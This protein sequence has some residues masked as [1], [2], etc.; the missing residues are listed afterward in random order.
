MSSFINRHL[1]LSPQEAK[2]MLSFIQC[3]TLDQLI[4]E[5]IPQHIRTAPTHT[6]G[7]ATTEEAF[8]EHI[9][10]IA[11]QNKV[12][13]SY[14]GQG[15]YPTH[16]PSVIKRNVLENPGWYT[17]YTPYQS[18][19]AQGRLECLFYFQTI[20]CE[21]TKLPIANA[22]LLDEATAAAE[23]MFMMYSHYCSTHQ[24]NDQHTCLMDT[25]IFPQT[26]NVIYTRAKA[27]GIK[28]KECDTQ[29]ATL[30]EHVF[31]IIVQYPSPDGYIPDYTAFIQQ[32]QQRHIPV[33]MI[34]DI[35]SLC[36]LEPCGTLG[37]SIA[38]GST[39]RLG[40]PMGMGGPHAAFLACKDE[41]KRIIPG[42]IIGKTIDAHGKPCYRMA[43][44][45]R[46][47]HIKREKATSNICTAQA[48]L[49]NMA[50]LYVIYHGAR[51]LMEISQRIASLAHLLALEIKA[52]DTH[53][54]NVIHHHYFD[55][56]TIAATYIDDIRKRAE[57]EQV[58]LFYHDDGQHIGIAL[59]ETTTQE[60]I[61]QLIYI[62]LGE[63]NTALQTTYQAYNTAIPAYA[64]RKDTFLTHEVFHSHTTETK[65]MRFLHHLEAKDLALNQSMIP[66]GSCTMKLNAATQLMPLSMPA[67]ANIHPLA[68]SAQQ[69]G[70]RFI[71]HR[72][73]QM[74]CSITQMDACS[75]QP[76]S[77]AQGE[78]AGLLCIKA[79]HQH[80]R[81]PQRNIMLIPISAHGT[82]PASA[83]VAG[84]DIMVIK[85]LDNGAIDLE[86]LQTIVQQTQGLLAGLMIT[87]PSTYGVFDANISQVTQLIHDAGG[88]VYMDGA[89]MN[90]QVGLTSPNT[91]GADVCH[92]NLHKTFAIPHGGGG[93]GMGPICV[94][95][96]L[97]P[98]LPALSNFKQQHTP[99]LA[100]I[101]AAPYGS[102]SI[103][104][105]AYAYIF[106]MGDEGLKKA[107]QYAILNANYL[108]KKIATTYPILYSN[109]N[110]RCAH[111]FIIDMRTLAQAAHISVEDIAKRL[112]DYGFHAPTVS[113]PIAGTLMVEPTESEDKAELDR[114]ADAMLSI[115]QEIQAII[116]Q[117]Y[118]KDNNPLKNAPHSLD[119][120]CQD[121]W[122]FPYTRQQAGFPLDYV[123]E[124]KFWIPVSRVNQAQGDRNLICS[125]SPIEDYV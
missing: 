75:L 38:V 7:Q 73:E 92:I 27:M 97:S 74:L 11:Q 44:Q 51:G 16:T 23:A 59:S 71:F 95:K 25:A 35:M 17:Q 63:N 60:D 56:L 22:S 76:N 72:L 24:K 26:K 29:H 79:Y 86:H 10:L 19:I 98:F 70:Y 106:M 18:E 77:G 88:L 91:I 107:T 21:L 115:Y 13:K 68:P 80:H 99:H 119:I 30:D 61:I 105:I 34:A 104:L 109:E 69:E 83:K 94:K 55:T 42:R 84:F 101:S 15:Y 12:Y 82:N 54:L 122:L 46:E 121:E 113:F 93:P 36:L 58:N 32:C 114:F 52:R 28:V 111:E 117:Q 14:I 3:D 85:C 20:I 89:N 81:Q 47:Q 41:Y 50:A 90:A 6:I 110:N 45:T 1:G 53:T 65:M 8:L 5:T 78:Y 62:L 125:C 120:L 87:Y 33:C 112:M 9:E 123:R 31:G 116:Q 103:L 57:Q 49:A 100:F 96:H 67:F 66:L 48:L 2:A 124:N 118:P 4:D 43:L 64:T 37:A 102:A 108:M 40:I 39:Q